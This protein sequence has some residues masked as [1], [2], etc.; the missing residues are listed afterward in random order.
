MSCGKGRLGQPS[1]F[2]TFSIFSTTGLVSSSV[3]VSPSVC[4]QLWKFGFS[5]VCFQDCFTIMQKQMFQLSSTTLCFILIKIDFTLRC[6]SPNQ[7]S[8]W[9]A[10][11]NRNFEHETNVSTHKISHVF[12]RKP[13]AS[14]TFLFFMLGLGPRPMSNAKCSIKQQFDFI[15]FMKKLF[16]Q[17][18]RAYF[19]VWALFGFLC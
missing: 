17:T 3:S 12:I 8:I 16:I 11:F 18:Q 2:S 1:R 13:F 4:N 9:V 6:L 7:Q 10:F 19:K 15:F 14:R 5:A